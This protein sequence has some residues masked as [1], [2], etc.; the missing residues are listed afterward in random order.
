MWDGGQCQATATRAKR[1]LP[2]NYVH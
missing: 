1:E 2:V